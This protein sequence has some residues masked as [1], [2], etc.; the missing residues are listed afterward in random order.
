MAWNWKTKAGL[1]GLAAGCFIAGALVS[2]VFNL[3]PKSGAEENPSGDLDALRRIGQGFSGVVKQVSPSV[4]NIRVSKTVKSSES[5]MG[6]MPFDFFG[7]NPFEQFFDTP[8]GG[9]EDYLE[10]GTGSGVIVSPDGY[11][12]TNNHVVEGADDI[13]VKTTDGKEFKAKVVGTDPHTDLAVI[14]VEAAGL[15]AAKLGDSDKI[16]VGEWVLAIGSPFDLSNS[17]TSGIISARGRAN[18]GLADYEDFIQTDAAI[19]PGNSGGPLVNLDGE[20]IGINSAIATRTGGYM[21]IGFAIPVNMAK[22]VMDQLIKTGKVTRGWLGV[23]IQPVTPEFQK[24]FG[25]KSAEGALIS[26]I[27]AGGPSEKAGLKRGD[28]IVRF[29]GQPVKDTNQ[30]R[31]AVAATKVGIDA[32]GVVIRDGKEKTFAVKVGE[33]PEKDTASG[34]QL[35]EGFG[36]DLGFDVQNLTPEIRQRLGV[37]EGQGGVVVM[38]VKQAGDAY[39]KGL[40]RGDVIVEVNRTPISSVADYNRVIGGV[41]AGDQVLLVVITEGHTRYVSFTVGK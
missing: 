8:R 37:P 40:R 16:E 2:G 22:N 6:G 36:G 3:V 14:K 13:T 34:G 39:Q 9:G 11:I 23:Y 31:N 5:T 4:V 7:G 27:T 38:D 33:L 21:G 30:L 17:V 24:Q 18:V 32:E 12:L 41:K 25:L 1:A 10:Q 28:V 20:V 19:N 35:G 15:T 26:D 29:K